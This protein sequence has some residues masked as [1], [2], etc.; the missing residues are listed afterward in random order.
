VNLVPH[1]RNRPGTLGF[2]RDLP[3]LPNGFREGLLAVDME[4]GTKRGLRDQRMLMVGHANTDRID[5]SGEVF[6][7]LPKVGIPGQVGPL[8]VDVREVPL[9]DIAEGDRL[10]IRVG[11][12]PGDVRQPLMFAADAGESKLLCSHEKSS[13]EFKGR[14]EFEIA[15]AFAHR[16]GNAFSKSIAVPAVR[17][18]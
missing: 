3:R 5:L 16:V 13:N 1:A 4:T 8:F 15:P 7:E 11:G 17:K 6:K 10:N 18:A 12:D 14:G 2:P 9:I